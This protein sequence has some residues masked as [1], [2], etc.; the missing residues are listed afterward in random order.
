MRNQDKE[1]YPGGFRSHRPLDHSTAHR[2][3]GTIH[4]DI[5]SVTSYI[6]CS[7]IRQQLTEMTSREVR[8]LNPDLDVY[9]RGLSS[10][11]PRHNSTT[12][13]P[14][15]TTHP[16]ISS[17]TIYQNTT[18]QTL[19]PFYRAAQSFYESPLGRGIGTTMNTGLNSH[20]ACLRTTQ[21]RTSS[22]GNMTGYIVSY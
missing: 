9:P 16:D 2:P 8:M 15:G 12:L 10:G 20:S 18:S 22:K 7:S 5:L 17:I 19:G 3:A 11:R 1:E 14:Q 13:T 21:R 6:P 4:P